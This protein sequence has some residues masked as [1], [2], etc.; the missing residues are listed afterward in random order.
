MRTQRTLGTSGPAPGDV[1]DHAAQP[2]LAESAGH[3]LHARLEPGD[4]R[5]LC[6]DRT[7]AR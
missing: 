4:C 3:L 2:G 6:P 7:R 5:H 1:S